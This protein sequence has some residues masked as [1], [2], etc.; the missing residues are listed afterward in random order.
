MIMRGESKVVE[1]WKVPYESGGEATE[2]TST[3]CTEKLLV[4]DS[5]E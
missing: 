1:H 4:N 2:G 3:Y 5:V